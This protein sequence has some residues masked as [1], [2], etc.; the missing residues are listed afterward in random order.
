MQNTISS[1]TPGA[2][3]RDELVAPANPSAEPD[4][5]LL[6]SEYEAAGG[7]LQQRWSSDRVDQV[8]FT[9]WPGQSQDGKKHREDLDGEPKPWEGA[10][11]VR[12]PKADEVILDLKATLVTTVMR[13]VVSGLAGRPEAEDAAEYAEK[14]IN[15]FRRQNRR[16]WLRELDLFADYTLNSGVGALQTGWDTSLATIEKTITL[17]ELQGDPR[18]APVLAALLERDSDDEEIL[19][20]VRAALDVGSGELSDREIIRLVDSLKTTG[21]ATYPYTYVRHNKPTLT[22]RKYGDDVFWPSSTTDLDRARVVFILDPM[23]EGELRENII[24]DE[25][26]EAFVDEAIKTAGQSDDATNQGSDYLHEEGY[27]NDARLD[28][29]SHSIDIVWAYYRQIDERGNPRLMCTVFCPNV[30]AESDLTPRSLYAKHGPVGYWHGKLPIIADQQ[31]RLNRRLLD[32]RGVPEIAGTW[33]DMIKAQCDMLVDRSNLEVNPAMTVPNRLGEKYRTGPGVKMKKFLG[34]GVEFMEPPKGN[35]AL[36][37]NLMEVVDRLTA[38]YF[39]TAHADVLPLAWQLR[40]QYRAAFFM[41]AVEESFAQVWQLSEQYLTPAE[42]K[43][44]SGDQRPA[45]GPELTASEV[46]FELAFDVR[47]LDMEYTTQKLKAIQQFALPLDRGGMIDYGKMVGPVMNA[48]DPALARTVMGDANGAAQR[49]RKDV[50]TDVLMM[51][52]GNEVNYPQLDPAAQLKQQFLRDIV[53]KNPKYQQALQA[54]ERFQQLML[55]YEK[56][57]QQS[58]SQLGENKLAGLTGVKEVG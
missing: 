9:R 35:P 12:I 30:N 34:Q 24:T 56:S 41:A 19:A 2:G 52:A 31:E 14:T 36:A 26:S 18:M 27:E 1:G 46:G 39:G 29:D 25:W 32:S 50:E 10:S 22:A 37:F 3:D 13:G 47:D 58:I 48:I 49:V 45:A 23:H 51:A 6:Y 4:L 40:L 44:I 38:K 11:D 53:K 42:R 55:N 21:E 43:F 7:E 54:D 20:F 8:R 5:D 33:Q 16:E 28:V 17:Q 15:H 57:L